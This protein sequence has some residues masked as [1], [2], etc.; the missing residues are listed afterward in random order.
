[1]PHLSRPAAQLVANNAIQTPK[2]RKPKPIIKST[3]PKRK[4]TT[5]NPTVQF[6]SKQSNTPLTKLQKKTQN[7]KPPI[8]PNPTTRVNKLFALKSQ[9]YQQPAKPANSKAHQNKTTPEN[10]KA[11]LNKTQAQTNLQTTALKPT[12]HRKVCKQPNQNT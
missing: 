12:N 3:Y 9:N 6:K 1:M 5:P 7:S 11:K 4:P 10:L 2:S 8:H